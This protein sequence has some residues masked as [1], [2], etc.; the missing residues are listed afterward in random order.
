LVKLKNLNISKWPVTG[1]G[2]AALTGMTDL[3]ILNLSRT[4]ITDAGLAHIATLPRL[5]QLYLE[6]TPITNDAIAHLNMP[7][8]QVLVLGHTGLNIDSGYDQ[9]KNMILA[10]PSLKSISLYGV[11]L[12]A[13]NLARLRTDCPGVAFHVN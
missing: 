11:T 5:E 13:A 7:A 2:L 8:L 1:S 6:F 12:S 10:K 3:R 4:N 9:F